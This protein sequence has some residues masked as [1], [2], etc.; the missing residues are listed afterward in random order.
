MKLRRSALWLAVVI[1]VGVLFTPQ[2]GAAG[3][4]RVYVPEESPRMGEPDDGGHGIAAK[5]PFEFIPTG[6][7]SVSF[8]TFVSKYY[9]LRNIPTQPTSTSTLRSGAR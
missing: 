5:L 1:A 7:F 3:P 6:W 8:A 9:A 2:R 4:Y